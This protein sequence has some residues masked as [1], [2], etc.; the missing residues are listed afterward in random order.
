M[1][2]LS[3]YSDAGINAFNANQN[4]IGTNLMNSISAQQLNQQNQMAQWNAASQFHPTPYGYGFVGGY[5]S[6]GEAAA[7][8]T[9][10]PGGGRS[11]F[12]GVSLGGGGGG[13]V[14]P[15]PNVGS[16]SSN[17]PGSSGIPIYDP[18][19]GAITGYNAPRQYGWDANEGAPAPA[20]TPPFQR[21]MFN[22][23]TYGWDA[24]EGAPAPAAPAQPSFQDI[25][26][27]RGRVYQPP[28]VES[29]YGP[30]GYPA[31]EP[32]TPQQQ[33][34]G[35][36]MNLGSNQ[37]MPQYD[38]WTGAITGYSGGGGGYDMSAQSRA[39]QSPLQGFDWAQSYMP[40]FSTGGAM[41]QALLASQYK[42]FDTGGGYNPWTSNNTSLPAYSQ[43]FG[44]P[45]SGYLGSQG[46]LNQDPFG[47]YVNPRDLDAGGSFPGNYQPSYNALPLG[48]NNSFNN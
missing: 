11:S 29:P 47:G 19:T 20:Y 43:M 46:R 27:N 2:L 32:R 44:M 40:N 45:G 41:Q 9:Y 14:D 18:W 5:P 8:G 23:H 42:P 16:G 6:F 25:W 3:G 13:M 28:K 22:P 26:N 39:Y 15:T 38:P 1:E 7:P 48:W 12:S 34:G 37:G 21:G 33:S 30:G 10:S 31:M 36:G 24:N 4:M 35:F 17:Y